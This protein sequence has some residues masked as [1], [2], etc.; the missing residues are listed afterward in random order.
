MLY[1]VIAIILIST[2]SPP[3][4]NN[5]DAGP[6]RHTVTVTQFPKSQLI[7]RRA[8]LAYKPNPSPSPNNTSAPL[9]IDVEEDEDSER[10]L[11][12][13]NQDG[14]IAGRG[15]ASGVNAQAGDGTRVRA[16]DGSGMGRNSRVLPAYRSGVIARSPGKEGK[17]FDGGTLKTT[18]SPPA[19]MATSSPILNAM[20]SQYV[21]GM[22]LDMSRDIASMQRK[23]N[24]YEILL[25]IY[26]KASA[27][28][29]VADIAELQQ[30]LT[31]EKNKL[32]EL[33]CFNASTPTHT[34]MQGLQNIQIYPYVNNNINWSHQATLDITDFN[35]PRSVICC[36][37]LTSSFKLNKL[38]RTY[39][40][41]GVSIITRTSF[42]TTGEEMFRYMA[43]MHGQQYMD[44]VVIEVKRRMD[45]AIP[46][47]ILMIYST[48]QYV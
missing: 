2:S 1:A 17:E 18:F 29:D 43:N 28:Q 37:L 5:L 33:M 34:P 16:R 48:V 15:H 26:N 11:G 45:A 30:L 4:E 27:Q 23:K 13:E 42:L 25:S 10:S 19:H 39:S 21:F 40:S 44:E 9:L 35:L 6:H 14:D 3:K 31:K 47:K 32:I 24:R 8:A 38:F 12:D 20:D 22:G 46:G 7:A 41:L 36:N